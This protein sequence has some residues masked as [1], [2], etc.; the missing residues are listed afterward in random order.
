MDD[1]LLVRRL[2]GIRNLPRDRQRLVESRPS[3]ALGHS[4]GESRSFDQFQNERV[5]RR[6]YPRVRIWPRYSDG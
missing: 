1:A 2:E 4:F 6:H 5:R 3:P